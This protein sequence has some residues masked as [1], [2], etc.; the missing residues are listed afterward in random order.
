MSGM[1]YTVVMGDFNATAGEGKE[2]DC[3]GHYGLGCRNERA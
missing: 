2:E 3:V 1:D